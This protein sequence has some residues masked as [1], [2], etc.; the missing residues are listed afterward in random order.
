MVSFFITLA[1]GLYKPYFDFHFLTREIDKLRGFNFRV[2][3]WIPYLQRVHLIFFTS[4]DSCSDLAHINT[5]RNFSKIRVFPSKKN[6]FLTKN[7]SLSFRKGGD[8]KTQIQID[9][10]RTTPKNSKE[11]FWTMHRALRQHKLIFSKKYPKITQNPKIS[12]Y[13]QRLVVTWII[14]KFSHKR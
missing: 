9:R 5:R 14:E 1:D 4:S 2:C 13:S 10:C 7:S 12:A 3:F 11:Q 6:D 8:W